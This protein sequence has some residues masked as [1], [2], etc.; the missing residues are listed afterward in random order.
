MKQ[1][2]PA[3]QVHLFSG[4][5]PLPYTRGSVG[6]SISSLQA[7]HRRTN[8]MTICAVQEFGDA[9]QPTSVCGQGYGSLAAELRRVTQQ[10]MA[11]EGL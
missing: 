9:L 3:E 6:A 4:R 1:L 8:K 7:T 2:Q 11:R 10:C 5:H